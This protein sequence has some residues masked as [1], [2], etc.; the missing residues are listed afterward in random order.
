MILEEIG[1]QRGLLC[2][3]HDRRTDEARVPVFT[4][5][6][7]LLGHE[8]ITRIEVEGNVGRRRAD[9]GPTLSPGTV[10]ALGTVSALTFGSLSVVCP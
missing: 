5:R 1:E 9:L 8:G 10:R 7:V 2:V 4:C 6:E 3:R